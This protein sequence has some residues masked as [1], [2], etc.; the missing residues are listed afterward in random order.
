MR[1][2][3]VMVPPLQ[4]GSEPVTLSHPLSIAIQNAPLR[5]AFSPP[6]KY[7]CCPRGS[8]LSVL[9]APKVKCT[10]EVQVQM[11]LT[12]SHPENFDFMTTISMKKNVN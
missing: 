5:V 10:L 3:G 6:D 1:K 8:E 12:R 11:I 9:S 4:E 2:A 7:L